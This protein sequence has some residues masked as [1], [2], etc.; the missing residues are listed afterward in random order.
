MG[1]EALVMAGGRGSRLDPL[2]AFLPKP[3][4][5]VA[6][7]PVLEHA[8][9]MMAGHGVRQVAVSLGYLAPLVQ[10]YFG[11]GERLGVRIR[12]LVEHRPL[13]TAGAIGLFGDWRGALFVMNADILCDLDVRAMLARHRDRGA[14]ATVATVEQVSRL[15]TAALETDAEGRVVRYREKPEIRHQVAMGCY[16][17]APAVRDH[18]RAEEAVDMPELLQR[19]LDAGAP[20]AAYA[21]GGRWIDVGRPDDLLRAQSLLSSGDAGR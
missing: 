16:M 5:P 15:P 17:L 3:L 4:V 12:Y 14:A 13:G 11:D 1:L 19:L 2:T 21:H 6:D 18:L 10:A 8:I 7:R 20:V 9:R